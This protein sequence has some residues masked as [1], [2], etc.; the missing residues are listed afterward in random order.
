MVVEAIGR[1]VFKI[2]ASASAHFGLNNRGPPFSPQ[3]LYREII[4]S[5]YLCVLHTYS[6][7]IHMYSMIGY[8]PQLNE[9]QRKR[10]QSNVNGPVRE[11]N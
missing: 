1:D 7:M 9:L 3:L 10:C 4:L 2:L 8:L 6:N 5:L 11:L